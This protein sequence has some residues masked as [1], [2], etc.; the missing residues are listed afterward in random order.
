[1]IEIGWLT[2]LLFTLL[3]NSK[4]DGIGTN[5]ENRIFRCH[6]QIGC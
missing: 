1:M 2:K 5:L 3:I 4:Q 6:Y